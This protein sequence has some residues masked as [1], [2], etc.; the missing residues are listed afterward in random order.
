MNTIRKGYLVETLVTKPSEQLQLGVVELMLYQSVRGLCTGAQKPTRKW[1]KRGMKMLAMT[2][3]WVEFGLRTKYN[4]S[5]HGQTLLINPARDC[6]Y[7]D[8][9]DSSINVCHHFDAHQITHL[10]Y[11]NLDSAVLTENCWCGFY[12]RVHL[13]ILDFFGVFHST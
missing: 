3:G 9:L 13:K 5:W 6:S 7:V 10:W 11:H 12:P 4:L 1:I 8:N 2:R